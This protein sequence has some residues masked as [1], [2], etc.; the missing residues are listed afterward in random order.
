MAIELNRQ[1]MA[2]IDVVNYESFVEASKQRD[3]AP[4]L[5]SRQIKSLEEKLGVVLLKRSTRSLALTDAGRRL[6]QKALQV[7]QLEQEINTCTEDYSLTVSGTVRLTSVSHLSHNYILPLIY[8]IQQEYSNITFEVSYDDRRTDIIKENFDIAVRV[9]KPEN[10]SLIGQK[11]RDI[12]LLIVATPAYLK[13]HGHPVHIEQL[14]EYPAACYARKG[15]RRDKIHYYDEQ[16]QI[17][18]V[19]MEPAY[20]CNSGD[21][22]LQ[23]VKAGMYY[24]VVADYALTNELETGELIELFPGTIYSGEE[25]VYAVYPNRNLSF[26]ARLF[27]ERLKA[28]FSELKPNTQ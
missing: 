7:K 9:W 18:E 15:V 25:A 10:S 19:E 23:S 6:Y 16:K 17:Q 4:S 22:L 26:A 20:K 2:F 12:K 21:F 1:L 14:S 3:I 11:L 24:A 13:K 28:R 5:L 8:S 27:V